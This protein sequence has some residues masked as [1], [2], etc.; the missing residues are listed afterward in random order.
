VDPLTY[1]IGASLSVATHWD[2]L[3]EAGTNFDDAHMF[4]LSASYRF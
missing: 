3:A 2:I 1:Q 4:V